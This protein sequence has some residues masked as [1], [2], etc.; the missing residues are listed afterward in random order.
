MKLNKFHIEVEVQLLK[1][2]YRD[3]GS[4]YDCYAIDTQKKE[5]DLGYSKAMFQENNL[6]KE[7]NNVD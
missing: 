6:L 3:D 2:E 1:T 4:I 7:N 5:I